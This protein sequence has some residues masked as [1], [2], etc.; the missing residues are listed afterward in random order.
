M[1]KVD[2]PS[3]MAK[4]DETDLRRFALAGAEKRLEELNA[5]AEQIFRMFPQL[6]GGRRRAAPRTTGASN[7]GASTGRRRR[8]ISAE[9]RRRISEAQK[10]RWARQ[11]AQASPA[12]E[13]RKRR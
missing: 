11:R 1:D 12:K 6:R 4:R 10:A 13:A 5:E 7:E 3:E 2:Y 8:R 9:G